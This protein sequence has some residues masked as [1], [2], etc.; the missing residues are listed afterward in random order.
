MSDG[1]TLEQVNQAFNKVFRGSECPHGFFIMSFCSECVGD[2]LNFIR[3]N[4]DEIKN[5]LRI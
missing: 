3:G 5:R 4:E 1:P 2:L